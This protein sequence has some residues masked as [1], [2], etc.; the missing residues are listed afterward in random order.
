MNWATMDDKPPA[1]RK[2]PPRSEI[3]AEQGK[4]IALPATAGEPQGTLLARRVPDKD[5]VTVAY[6]LGTGEVELLG[7][8]GTDEDGY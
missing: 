1:N 4:P 7:K 8:N 5:S 2:G 6:A 3:H